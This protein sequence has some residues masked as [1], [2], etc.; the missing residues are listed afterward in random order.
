MIFGFFFKRFWVLK[1]GNCSLVRR[2]GY[3]LGDFSY[4]GTKDFLLINLAKKAKIKIV[5]FRTY[6]IRFIGYILD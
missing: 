1:K 5:S 4:R 2:I 3:T 6:G